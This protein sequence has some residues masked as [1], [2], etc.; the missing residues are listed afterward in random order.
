LSQEV[1]RK[2][3]AAI[4]ARLFKHGKINNR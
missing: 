3:I 1:H 4:K 2:T